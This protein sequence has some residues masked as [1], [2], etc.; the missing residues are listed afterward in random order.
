MGLHACNP[1]EPCYNVPMNETDDKLL[2]LL[3]SAFEAG[4]SAG[5]HSEENPASHKEDWE[6]FKKELDKLLK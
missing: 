4:F 1:W 5:Y 3:E 6:D 2:E